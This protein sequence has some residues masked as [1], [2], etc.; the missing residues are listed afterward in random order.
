MTDLVIVDSCQGY[1]F[2]PWD[3]FVF[4]AKDLEIIRR[5][6]VAVNPPNYPYHVLI[7]I[8]VSQYADLEAY[9]H[10]HELTIQSLMWYK[11]G[12]NYTGDSQKLRWSCGSRWGKARTRTCPKIHCCDTM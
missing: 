6:L 2:A 11:A 3:D 8:R 10:E 5:G 7:F 12:M 4:N 9:C 1:N